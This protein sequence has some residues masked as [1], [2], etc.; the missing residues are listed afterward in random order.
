MFLGLPSSEPT[1]PVVVDPMGEL[2]WMSFLHLL[3]EQKYEPSNL[4]QVH[5]WLANADAFPV[6]VFPLPFAP[7][8]SLVLASSAPHWPALDDV[9]ALVA[10]VDEPSAGLSSTLAALGC[11]NTRSAGLSSTLAALGCGNARC[12][13]EAA[14]VISGVDEIGGEI[15]DKYL[16]PIADDE[17]VGAEFKLEGVLHLPPLLHLTTSVHVSTSGTNSSSS[18]MPSNSASESHVSPKSMMFSPLLYSES[19][20]M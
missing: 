14:G 6:D 16:R 5:R 2:T 7:L 15:V 8:G 20:R 17:V 18:Y 10:A 9:V 19:A 11:R 3:D 4:S 13:D 1:R 12:D